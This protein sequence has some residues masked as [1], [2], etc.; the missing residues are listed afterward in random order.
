M[1]NAVAR[2]YHYKSDFPVASKALRAHLASLGELLRPGLA[3]SVHPV[4]CGN[5]TCSSFWD[6]DEKLAACAGCRWA[7]CVGGE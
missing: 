5:L 2:A 4:L 1:T 7:Q 3:T 6:E